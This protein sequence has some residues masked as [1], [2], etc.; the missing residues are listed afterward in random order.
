MNREI[1]I[2]CV[3]VH[4]CDVAPATHYLEKQWVDDYSRKKGGYYTFKRIKHKKA[5]LLLDFEA[6]V[7]VDLIVQSYY[8]DGTNTFRATSKRTIRNVSS[9]IDEFKLP[10]KLTEMSLYIGEETT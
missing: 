10:I 4:R 2:K 1:I 3:N 6:E 9:I 5:K 7:D 8:S